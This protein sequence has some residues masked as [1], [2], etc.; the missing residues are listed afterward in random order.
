MCSREEAEREIQ[1]ARKL[2]IDFVGVGEVDYPRR[3]QMIDDPPLIA[4]RGHRD[5]FTMP[6]VAIVGSRNAS[7]GGI[8]LT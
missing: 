8:K 6:Q 2:G 7:A 1:T 5:V 3:L 4:V